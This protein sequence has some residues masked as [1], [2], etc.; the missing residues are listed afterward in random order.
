[1]DK[2]ISHPT[3]YES[4]FI[5]FQVMPNHFHGIIGIGKNNFNK[6]QESLIFGSRDALQCVSTPKD[7]DD[8]F[9]IQNHFG[10]Q[11]KNL[12]SIIRGFKGSVTTF[13]RKQHLLI[14]WQSRFHEHII[15]N[16]A[17]L[18][19]IKKYIQQNVS[20]WEKDRFNNK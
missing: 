1:M 8:S 6:Y 9:A 19:K 10:P 15:N 14:D 2:N 5:D 3:R 7:H 16:D 12:A 4:I 20:N 13:A 18:K 17:E 11:R